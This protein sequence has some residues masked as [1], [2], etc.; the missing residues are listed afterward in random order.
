MRWLD[1]HAHLHMLEGTM[2][3]QLQAAELAGLAGLITV[4]TTPEDLPIVV[5]HAEAEYPFVAASIGIHPHDAKHYDPRC[6]ESEVGSSFA[7]ETSQLI[8]RLAQKTCVVA[9]GEI[10]L[11]YYYE[12]S[13]RSLQKD[14]F[15]KQMEIAKK[16]HYPVEIHTRDAEPDTHE[17]LSEYKGAVRGIIHCFTGTKEFA[18]QALDLGYNISFSGIITFKN[19]ESLREV[20]DFVPLDRMHVETDA[21]FLAPVPVRGKKNI[22]AFLPYTGK[23]VAERRQMTPERFAEQMFQ[24]AR[25]MFPRWGLPT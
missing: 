4:G 22:P 15:R 25:G 7:V 23:F 18:R 11:D 10:G 6:D 12:N 3:E 13:D 8:E 17:V 21:P 5:A 20:L 2:G 16:L 19:A 14:A 1:V 9:I 24:N